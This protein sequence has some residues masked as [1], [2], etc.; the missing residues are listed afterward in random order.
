MV[1]I[2]D[3]T[4][5][6]QADGRKLAEGFLPASNI[7]M[8]MAKGDDDMDAISLKDIARDISLLN[9]RRASKCPVGGFDVC[10]SPNI[11]P[12]PDIDSITQ[13]PLGT[14]RCNGELWVSEGCS[15]G[16]YCDNTKDIGGDIK[17]C[18]EVTLNW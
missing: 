17:I 18:E 11:E 14:C 10:P 16:F 15:Y 2:A 3:A 8:I 13:N 5:A 6:C 4:W 9:E 7:D 1:S 12:I